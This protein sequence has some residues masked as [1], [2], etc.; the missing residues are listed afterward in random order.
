MDQER[1]LRNASITE[2]ESQRNHPGASPRRGNI[3]SYRRGSNKGFTSGT[4]PEMIVGGKLVNQNNKERAE[5]KEQFYEN[6]E[7]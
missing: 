4:R 1:T 6:F 7:T 5:L 2:G 3:K